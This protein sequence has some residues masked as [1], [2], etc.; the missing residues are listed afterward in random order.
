MRVDLDDIQT[1]VLRSVDPAFSFYV[2]FRISDVQMF[3]SFLTSALAQTLTFAGTPTGLYAERARLQ[4]RSSEA[5]T[6][7]STQSHL[8]HMNVGFTMPGLERL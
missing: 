6:V 7:P 3:R 8:L 4:Y 2:F 1:N 5:V